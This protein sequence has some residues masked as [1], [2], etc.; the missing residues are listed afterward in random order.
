MKIK[1]SRNLLITLA[2]VIGTARLLTGCGTTAN[3]KQADKTGEGIAEFR[4]EV[5]KV[6]QAVDATLTSINQIQI[7]A[8]TN[9]RNAFEQFSKNVVALDAAAGKAKQR[10]QDMK[11]EGAAYFDRWEKQLAQL[12]N[13]EIKRLAEQRKTKL[14]DAFDSIK[15]ISEPLRAQFE[16]WLSDVKD[17]QKYLSNDLTIDGVDTARN[18]IAK[19]KAE[20]AEVE[21]SM[22]ALVAELNTIAAALTPAKVPTK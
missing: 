10:G 14:R 18:L 21:K 7:T 8:N 5:V 9:P 17:L 2:A 15:K 11:S 22:D 12:N 16:P 3:Y 6:K 4:I 20:G 19:S 13:P 1:T